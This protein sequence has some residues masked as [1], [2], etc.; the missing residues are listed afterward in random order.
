MLR[1]AGVPSKAL[2]RVTSPAGL[3]LGPCTQ[4][5][6]AVAILAEIVAHGH[7]TRNTTSERLCLDTRAEQAADPVCG[8]TVAVVPSTLSARHRERT[9]YFCSSHCREAFVR[10]PEGFG[11]DLPRSQGA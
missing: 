6:I 8:M 5:E 2:E 7:R 11:G 9:Y 4:E 3:D 10:E 1:A